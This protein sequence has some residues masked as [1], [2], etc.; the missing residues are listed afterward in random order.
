M[1]VGADRRGRA[2]V[3]VWCDAATGPLTALRQR[4]GPGWGSCWARPAWWRGRWGPGQ[5]GRSRPPSLARPGGLRYQ[6]GLGAV[7]LGHREQLVV[8]RPRRSPSRSDV[9]CVVGSHPAVAPGTGAVLQGTRL[10]PWPVLASAAGMW[11]DIRAI[12]A[13]D[14]GA[15]DPGHRCHRQHRG[16]LVRLLAEVGA[17]VRALVRSPEKAPSIQRLGLETALGDFQQPDSLDAAMAGCD[18]LFLLSPPSPTS[19]GRN[20]TH[21]RGQAG[22]GRACGRAVGAGVRP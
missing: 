20:A 4:P 17:P 10:A 3:G 9:W 11:V 19:P 8:G 16:E 1:V 12:A 22:R 13:R 18:H 2:G 15:R 14:G 21:R 6:P 7:V 5:V